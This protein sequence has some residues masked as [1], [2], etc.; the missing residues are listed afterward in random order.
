VKLTRPH[1]P[2]KPRPAKL[3]RPSAGPMALL[4]EL[5]AQNRIAKVVRRD[6]YTH[7]T[8]N[9]FSILKRGIYGM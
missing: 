9:Y 8:E 5:S 2:T 3:L 4:P 7:A 1:L 6:V